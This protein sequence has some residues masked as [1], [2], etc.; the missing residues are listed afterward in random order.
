MSWDKEENDPNL[1]V[2]LVNEASGSTKRSKPDISYLEDAVEVN[3]DGTVKFI[4]FVGGKVVIERCVEDGQ[5]L[6]TNLYTVTAID[7]E[8]GA[9]RLIRDEFGHNAMSNYMEGILRGYVFKLP[10]K[11][12]PIVKRKVR[13][14][15]KMKPTLTVPSDPNTPKKGRGRPKGSKNRPREVIQ[16]EK[17]QGKKSGK[18][19]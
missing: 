8:T 15:K 14:G 17:A 9:L 1:F 10:P 7:E 6:D 5:W 11:K 12:G 4:P 2:D 16:A 3:D 19:V 18:P 13:V